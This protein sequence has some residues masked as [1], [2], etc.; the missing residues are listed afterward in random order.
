M[1]YYALDCQWDLEHA[2]IGRLYLS[3]HLGHF[4]LNFMFIKTVD[5]RQALTL[6]NLVKIRASD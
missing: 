1:K 6:V 5:K 3:S 4:Y 2:S